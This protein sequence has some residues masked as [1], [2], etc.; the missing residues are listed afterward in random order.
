[1]VDLAAAA[2]NLQQDMQAMTQREEKLTSTRL[3]LEKM[4]EVITKQE[5]N[6]KKLEKDRDAALVKAR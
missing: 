1:L 2:E 4:Q 5:A 3:K 6:V